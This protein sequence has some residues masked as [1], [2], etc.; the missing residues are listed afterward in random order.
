PFP[1][2]PKGFK[3]QLL[4]YRVSST[5]AVKACSPV[6]QAPE[7]LVAN[8]LNPDILN[9]DIL[10]PDILNSDVRNASVFIAPGDAARVQLRVFDLDKFDSNVIKIQ[11]STSTTAKNLLA[12]G[13]VDLDLGLFGDVEIAGQPLTASLVSHAVD[14]ASAQ[15]GITQPSAAT[16]RLTITT[17]VLPSGRVGEP[18]SYQ[19]LASGGTLPL[20]WALAAGSILPANLTLSP[21]GLLSGT[22]AAAGTFAFT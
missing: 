14:T 4:V 13:A 2:R 11:Q 8:I 15:A 5:P 17:T 12:A 7:Q 22:P 9:P 6:Q 20:A 18:F 21:T 10:N 1:A 19:L 3:L 16:T